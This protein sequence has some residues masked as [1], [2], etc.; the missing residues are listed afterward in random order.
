MKIEVPL[1][2][3]SQ[4]GLSGEYF[5]LGNVWTTI[6]GPSQTALSQVT[7]QLSDFET[8]NDTDELYITSC[9]C[10]AGEIYVKNDN[11]VRTTQPCPILSCL[12]IYRP[13]K[14]LKSSELSCRL[15]QSSIG[16]QAVEIKERVDIQIRKLNGEPIEKITW[17]ARVVI[18]LY[19][20]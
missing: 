10:N 15:C 14:A 2:L 4:T 1:T 17:M 13:G 9:G 7:I 19:F 18:R 3:V 12:A 16:K 6:Y 20:Q 5:E 11:I 8:S